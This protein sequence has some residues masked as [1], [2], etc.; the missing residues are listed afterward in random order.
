MEMVK[1]AG[2]ICVTMIRY[3]ATAI[4]RDDKI[5]TGSKDSLSVF[6]RA[7]VMLWTEATIEAS[8]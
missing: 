3:L 8:S 5:S 6:T 1:A 7:K 4:T 2:D